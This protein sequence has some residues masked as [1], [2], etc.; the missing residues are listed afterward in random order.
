MIKDVINHYNNGI[1]AFYQNKYDEAKEAFLTHLLDVNIENFEKLESYKYLSQI[2]N[3]KGNSSDALKYGRLALDSYE[4]SNILEKAEMCYV[5]FMICK[6]GNQDCALEYI[7][8]GLDYIG[9]SIDQNI[10]EVKYKLEVERDKLIGSSDE[11]TMN[12]TLLEL[13]KKNP[14][15]YI[16][17][18]LEEFLLVNENDIKNEDI[19]KK[20]K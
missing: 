7:D 3:N 2:F 1:I 20:L 17:D 13:V 12:A 16:N 11:K 14:E 15:K 8:I 10:L 6:T 5:L 4:E 9:D 19:Y 18:F